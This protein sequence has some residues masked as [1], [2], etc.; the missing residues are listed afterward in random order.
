MVHILAAGFD[1]VVNH[2]IFKESDAIITSVAG[3]HGPSMAEWVIMNWVNHSRKYH[4]SYEQQKS[5]V[6]GSHA[7][8]ADAYDYAGK[9]V[10]IVGYGSIGRHSEY[11]EE[12]L[13][14]FYRENKV[15]NKERQLVV[16]QRQWV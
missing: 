5:H 1:P 12:M 2:P 15:A 8:W 9:T 7:Q 3:I 4:L 16:L 6:W 14:Y 10:G 13:C 11:S